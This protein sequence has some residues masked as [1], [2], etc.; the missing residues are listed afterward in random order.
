MSDQNNSIFGLAAKNGVILGL[1]VGIVGILVNM[2]ANP[3]EPSPMSTVMGIFVGVG[4]FALSLYM[5]YTTVKT[6]R[7]DYN[8]GMIKVLQAFL[9]GL[10]MYFVA[11]LVASIL[12]YVYFSFLMPDSRIEQMQELV[13]QTEERMEDAPEFFKNL[14]SS[15]FD[16]MLN[17]I[18]QLMAPF[19]WLVWSA[20]KSIVMALIM[21]RDEAIVEV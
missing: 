5:N 14:T 9:I 18:K 11:D 3:F 8:N 12:N 21:K 20:I 6:V 7:D 17:P 19:I 4:A 16:S 15:A 2:F 10:V 13:A 1:I